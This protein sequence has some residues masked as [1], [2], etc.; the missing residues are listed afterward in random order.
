MMVLKKDRIFY[1]DEIRALAI[2]LVLLAHTIQEF[3]G[4]R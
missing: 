1:L 4:K 3:S 2:L